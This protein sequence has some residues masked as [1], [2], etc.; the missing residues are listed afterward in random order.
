MAVNRKV[1]SDISAIKQVVDV[2]VPIA[3]DNKTIS[4]N[5]IKA[6]LF[7]IKAQLALVMKV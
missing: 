5:A 7:H 1:I 4:I 2:R 3:Q 6:S